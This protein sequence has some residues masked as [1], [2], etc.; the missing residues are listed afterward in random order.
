MRQLLKGV[1]PLPPPTPG[2]P[3]RHGGPHRPSRSAE[4]LEVRATRI[5]PADFQVKLAA[6]YLA[7]TDKGRNSLLLGADALLDDLVY[8]T[9]APVFEAALQKVGRHLGFD[10][11]RPERTLG[12]GPDVL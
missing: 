10:S 6:S 1:G 7:N 5:S 9:R 8:P 4:L 3:I 2:G 11:Q 12:N